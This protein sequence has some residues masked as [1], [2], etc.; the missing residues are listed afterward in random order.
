LGGGGGLGQILGGDGGL[1]SGLF[2]GDI[3]GDLLGG[4]DGGL[5]SGLLGGNLLDGLLNGLFGGLLSGDGCW[6]ACSAEETVED[7]SYPSPVC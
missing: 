1:L 2:P 6:A 5:F 3:F 4:G 7:F